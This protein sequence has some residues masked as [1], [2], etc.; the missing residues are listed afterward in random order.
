MAG[1]GGPQ[2][3]APMAGGGGPQSILQL[4][5]LSGIDLETL[6]RQFQQRSGLALDYVN[7]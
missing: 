4:P 2:Q 1:G 7:S 3:A 5:P 6:D